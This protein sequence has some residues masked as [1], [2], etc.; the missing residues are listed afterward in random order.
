MNTGWHLKSRIYS[1]K[2]F[3]LKFSEFSE[4]TKIN[5]MKSS[6]KFLSCAWTNLI[7]L[8][9]KIDPKIVR[10]LIPK[11]LEVE[12]IDEKALISIVCF[13]FSKAKLMGISIPFHQYFPEINIR[14]YVHRKENPEQRGIY[15]LSEMVPKFMTFFVGK[16]IYKEP[17]E[18]THVKFNKSQ[19]EYQYLI[20][21]SQTNFNLKI[22]TT[23]DLGVETYLDNFLIHQQY[24][25]CGKAQQT[26]RLYKVQHRTWKK[27]KGKLEHY[28]FENLKNVSTKLEM[29]L[30]RANF[31]NSFWVDGSDVDV[32]RIYE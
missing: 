9:F 28:T 14:I 4:I 7:Y 21:E 19:N 16:Y 8:N 2:I 27:L 11:D 10:T 25:F 15:F 6:F 29:E 30:N 13:E 23:D 12:L 31:I 3:N 26:S 20:D 24:A 1:N 17:F 22:Q 32:Y 5:I 18:L